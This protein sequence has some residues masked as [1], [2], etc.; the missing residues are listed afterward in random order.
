M[1]GLDHA[2]SLPATMRHSDM[3]EPNRGDT[4]SFVPGNSKRSCEMV[5]PSDP[6]LK[7]RREPLAYSPALLDE[8]NL[9]RLQRNLTQ[10]EEQKRLLGGGDASLNPCVYLCL[11]S[12]AWCGSD[13][14]LDKYAT[15]NL[16][17]INVQGSK[18]ENQG[19]GALGKSSSME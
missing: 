12:L 10:P 2:G 1:A 7:R 14:T 17:N 4:R 16:L 11:C 6:P 15:T 18:Q 3:K 5:G 9:V 8:R 13:L 19:G